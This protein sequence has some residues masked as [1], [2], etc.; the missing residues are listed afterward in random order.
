MKMENIGH[1]HR[2]AD[3]SFGYC[4]AWYTKSAFSKKI[5]AQNKLDYL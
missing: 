4:R 1:C 3:G 5:I 2:Q